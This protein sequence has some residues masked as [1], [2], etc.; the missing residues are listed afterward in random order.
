M[1]FIG[2]RVLNGM[3]RKLRLSE[4]EAEKQG[5]KAKD[6]GFTPMQID[7]GGPQRH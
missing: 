5:S 3:S 4:A 1:C 2:G 7:R 6:V